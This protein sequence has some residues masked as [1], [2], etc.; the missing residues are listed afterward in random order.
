VLRNLRAAESGIAPL[1]FTDGLDQIR[2]GPFG[3]RLLLRSGG[4]EESIFEILEP[5]MK[6]QQGGG[7]EDYGR[8]DQPTRAQEPGTKPEEQAVGGAKIGRS[9]AG[10]LQ[11]QELLLQEDILSQ[12]G[13]G[14]ASSQENGQSGQQMPVLGDL[15]IQAEEPEIR[16][17]NIS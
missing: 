9:A 16:R 10:A 7:L 4:V 15:I 11:E 2:C 12:N 14:S 6:A 1:D 17:R 8:A 13:S 3:P 5:T